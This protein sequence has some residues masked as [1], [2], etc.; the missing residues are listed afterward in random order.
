MLGNWEDV[1]EAAQDMFVKAFQAIEAFDIS[2]PF[3]TWIYWILINTCVDYRRRRAV[4]TEAIGITPFS[5]FNSARYTLDQGVEA[6]ENRNILSHALRK[7]S[8]KHR[9]V[10]T[11]R[12]LQGLSSREVSQVLKCSEATVRVHL[13]NARR[14]LKKALRPLISEQEQ[15]TDVR[16]CPL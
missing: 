7:L 13:F 2:K 3:S 12:D 8:D 14:Q 1:R 5:A 9:V 4:V 6:F 11:L 15:T 10:I 16:G